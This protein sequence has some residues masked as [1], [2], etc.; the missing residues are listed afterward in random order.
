LPAF[1]TGCSFR[2][3]SIDSGG[4]TIY[5]AEPSSFISSRPASK[6]QVYSNFFSFGG[7]I[8]RNGDLAL[9]MEHPAHRAGFGHVFPAI[10]VIKWRNRPRSVSMPGDPPDSAAHAAGPVTFDMVTLRTICFVGGCRAGRLPRRMARSMFFPFAF[11][12][13]PAR[14]A[15]RNRGLEFG[16]RRPMRSRRWKCSRMIQWKTRPRFGVVASFL[17]CFDCCPF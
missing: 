1:G 3:V 12:F 16:H 8:L 5:H 10:F 2:F 15:V 13:L 14:M 9:A 17:L 4:V 6:N 11:S 7:C